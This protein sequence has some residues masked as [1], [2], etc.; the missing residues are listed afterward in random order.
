MERIAIDVMGPLPET[1][2]GNKFIVVIR[3]YFTKCMEAFT[4][5]DYKV[6]TIAKIL[7]EV[8]TFQGAFTPTKEEISKD[9]YSGTCAA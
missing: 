5:K 1:A 4:T 8:L 2:R 7:V 6:E 9:I 3:D